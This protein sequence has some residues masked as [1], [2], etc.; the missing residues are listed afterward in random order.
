[1]SSGWYHSTHCFDG[2]GVGNIVG[3]CDGAYDGAPDANVGLC[4]SVGW[5]VGGAVVG[6]GVGLPAAKPVA[7]V[8]A[9][10]VARA[11]T[12]NASSAQS[13]RIPGGIACGAPFSSALT[14]GK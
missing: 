7:C 13:A 2:A 11:P 10:V 6:I 5:S 14:A 3:A 12:A 9:V 1:M 4:E 8:G